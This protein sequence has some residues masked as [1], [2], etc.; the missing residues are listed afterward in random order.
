MTKTLISAVL[1][2]ILAVTSLTAAPARAGNDEVGAF[3]L[4]ATTLFLLGH[5]LSDHDDRVRGRYRY[6][7]RY[8]DPYPDRR[9]RDDRY[10][11]EPRLKPRYRSLPSVCLRTAETYR[12]GTIRFF[13]E[14]CLERHARFVPDVCRQFVR[15]PRGGKRAIYR[16]GCLRRHG[17]RFN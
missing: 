9:Y 8:G 13:G 15:G 10:Y 5:V 17:Y 16:A 11:R 2:A 1:A 4:G 14:R 6:E 12:H 7:F 3:I